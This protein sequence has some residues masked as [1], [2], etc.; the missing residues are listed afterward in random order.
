[1]SVSTV[2]ALLIILIAASLLVSIYLYR[3]DP[4][5]GKIFSAVQAMISIGGL[6]VAA[7][8]YF[9]E[10]K[11]M[12][13]VN[14]KLTAQAARMSEG[15]MFLMT[16]LDISNSG[17]GLLT[18]K[19]VDVRVMSVAMSP[20]TEATVQSLGI[21]EF[22]AMLPSGRNLYDKGELGW[23]GVKQYASDRSI[24][25]EPGETDSIF[26]DFVIPCD[27]GLLKISGGVRKP[28]KAEL[29]YKDRKVLSAASICQSDMAKAKES[30]VSVGGSQ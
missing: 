1:M 11:G 23:R 7:Y 12:P 14:V 6:L 20:P 25:I 28:G 24:E 8:W 22:P 4:E 17:T 30:V 10:R 5:F 16:R 13:H 27:N 26:V 9:V 15:S 18:I 19:N 21:D 3:R 2:I 29:W